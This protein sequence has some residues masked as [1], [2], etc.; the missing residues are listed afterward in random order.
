M[1]GAGLSRPAGS[2]LGAAGPSWPLPCKASALLSVGTAIFLRCLHLTLMATE[3]AW[4]RG[5][6]EL[7]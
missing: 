4:N 6:T 5:W 1:C 7:I 2:G 3:A